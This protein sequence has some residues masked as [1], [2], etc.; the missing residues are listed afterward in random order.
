MSEAFSQ[1]ALRLLR[2]SH[3]NLLY[4]TWL[5]IV[6]STKY[7]RYFKKVVQVDYQFSKSSSWE[8][9]RGHQE[10]RNLLVHNGGLLDESER[11]N[12]V[13]RFIKH[14]RISISIEDGSLSIQK[15][16]IKE[17]ITDLQQILTEMFDA[18]KK[19]NKAGA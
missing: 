15:N 14:R 2:H 7:K 1:L 13:R 5:A 12:K 6:Q 17:L 19:A 18:L 3:I 16:Y 4:L 8:R 11:S 9:I 10:I